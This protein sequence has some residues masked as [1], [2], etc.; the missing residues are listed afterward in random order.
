MPHFRVFCCVSST[1]SGVGSGISAA[2]A[3]A[4]CGFHAAMGVNSPTCV[5]LPMAMPMA[6]TPVSLESPME[7]GVEVRTMVIRVS[8]EL[9]GLVSGDGGRPCMGTW[10]AVTLPLRKLLRA[11]ERSSL[12]TRLS[13]AC[14]STRLWVSAQSAVKLPLRRLGLAAVDTVAAL[15]RVVVVGMTKDRFARDRGGEG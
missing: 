4:L 8:E 2:A 11:R 14:L 13:R 5:G 3:F 6:I 9:R 10:N 1:G 12:E 7:S 15:D